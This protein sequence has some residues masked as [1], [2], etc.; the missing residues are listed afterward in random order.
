MQNAN[1]RLL[2]E[3]SDAVKAGAN[4]TRYMDW[5]RQQRGLDFAAYDE[6]WSWSTSEPEQFWESLWQ[7]FAVASSSPHT[8]VL[9]ERRMPGAQWFPGARLNYAEHIFRGR[10]DGRPALIADSETRPLTEL[11]W[12]ELERQVAAV[13]AA[14][15]RFGVGP[16]DRVVAYL[17]NIPEAIVAALAAFSLGAVWSSCSPDFGTGAVVDRFRQIEP[18]VLFTVDGYRYGGKPQDR[19]HVIA[20][21]QAALPTVQQTVLVPYLDPAT[22]VPNTVPWPDLLQAGGGP[23]HFEQVPFDHPLY[24]LY[25][26]GTTGLPKPIVHGHGG[27]LLEHLKV[28]T[29]HQDIKPGDRFFW[30]T[31]TG[32]MMWNYIVSGL[33][34]GATLLLYDGS[35]AYPD[36]NRLWSFAEATGMTLF[37]TSAAYITSCMKA[38][39]E[40]G[41]TFDLS[42]LTN[43]SSTGSPLPP[44]GF[45]WVYR[46]RPAIWLSSVSGGTDMCT[47]FVAGCPVLPVYAGELQCRCL[48][49]AIAAFDEAGRP[50]TGEVGELVI[51]MPMPSMPLCFWNDPEQ[52][53]YRE[54][55]F[56]VY[57]G[58]WR[59]GDWIE[60]TLRGSAIIYGRSDSTI[61]R[62]G[63]RM[64]TSEIY[65][66]VE[67]LPE[68]L[69]SLVIDLE[70]LGGKSF[71][72]L[73]VVLKEGAALDDGLK[74]R[75]RA[76]L[77]ST[78]SPRHV[79]DEI[80]A[81]AQV[82][83]TIN[84]KKLEVPVKKI[85]MGQPV[86]KA[87][88]LD[89]MA[90]PQSLEFFV[91]LAGRLAAQEAP[92][93]TLA[94]NTT[95][96]PAETSANTQS[97]SSK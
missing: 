13:A 23:L 17:P 45:D 4:I 72:P 71:M 92:M 75:I 25:S 51:T 58:I 44:E 69:D 49:A 22:P 20:E 47:A 66:V 31:T 88:N 10:S 86:A 93:S 8:A 27:I 56:G 65:R 33:A 18:K 74:E 76:Q 12:A 40:P 1:G 48:G 62:H 9:A 6:L 59:H 73:F 60:I 42:R 97:P 15:R 7:F 80:I 83:R 38:G 24:I 64:G 95:T 50:L 85:L 78:L 28:L 52:K 35:P 81:I 36:L 32:W 96:T 63:V 77:R 94:V 39:I 91:D 68:V 61:N 30:Y 89:S 34:V 11:S 37:G 46:Q 29:L 90:N 41:K 87:A 19:R 54:S 14:L 5:L 53:R 55:Y 67:E 43:L 21:L 3:P 82:P 26:S 2:W 79:P 70:G 16:G 57:D 84:G